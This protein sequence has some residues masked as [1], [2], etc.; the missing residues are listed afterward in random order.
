MSFVTVAACASF[1][2]CEAVAAL[3]GS[4]FPEEVYSQGLSVQQWAQ[5]E[6]EDLQN[7]PSWWRQIGGKAGGPGLNLCGTRW[8]LPGLLW[9]ARSPDCVHGLETTAASE[10]WRHRQ[11]HMRRRLAAPTTA[12]PCIGRPTTCRAGLARD[13]GTSG[14]LLGVVVLT[15]EHEADDSRTWLNYS[16]RVGCVPTILSWMYDHVLDEPLL[17]R[18]NVTDWINEIQHV[19][20]HMER[21]G[22]NG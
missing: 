21:M 22:A 3:C 18:Q 14:R 7:T 13:G 4:T 20:N 1:Q 8:A 16:R 2:D 12:S 15:L 17:V 19:S 5:I 10:A 6:A 9:A 11:T